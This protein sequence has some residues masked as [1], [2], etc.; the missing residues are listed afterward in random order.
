[1]PDTSAPPERLLPGF[2][3]VGAMRGGTTSLVNY[4][5][6]HPDVRRPRTDPY[7]EIHFF[8][9]HYDRGMDW[10]RSHFPLARPGDRAIT[11]ASSP[12]A[13]FHPHA[14]ARAAAD[15][16]EARILILLRHPVQR[17]ISHFLLLRQEEWVPETSIDDVIE[18]ET[19]M[20]EQESARLFQEPL[21]HSLT[22]R[23]YSLVSRGVY[24]PQVQDWYAHFPDEQICVIKSETLY[25]RTAE[26]CER[27]QRF[28]GLEPF[29][30]H[31]QQAFNDSS[32]G[33]GQIPE[34]TLDAL[35]AFYAPHNEALYAFLADKGV[36][37]EPFSD[38]DLRR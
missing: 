16:P 29:P 2:L 26:V 3:I 32:R 15:L 19:R 12:Y 36:P 33:E 5:Y 1:M 24:L 20:I 14:A 35:A 8:D 23:T 27:V 30:I 38:A 17:A 11:G 37:F 34:A 31:R 21:Y 18:R 9:V 22:H 13:L 4:L 7:D 25:A 28:L 6:D 10:Y